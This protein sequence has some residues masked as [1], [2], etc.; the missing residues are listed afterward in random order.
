MAVAQDTALLPSF[1]LALLVGVPLP[2]CDELML[3]L[4]QGRCY[5]GP[6]VMRRQQAASEG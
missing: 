6:M 3:Y 1:P 4:A 2:Q 5:T